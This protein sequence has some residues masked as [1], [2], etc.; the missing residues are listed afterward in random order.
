MGIDELE[1]VKPD[2]GVIE[3]LRA[4]EMF[5]AEGAEGSVGDCTGIVMVFLV[6]FSSALALEKTSQ[7]HW[8]HTWVLT[9]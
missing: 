2:G 9:T 4:L 3:I 1:G 8:R 7:G 5:D 6:M